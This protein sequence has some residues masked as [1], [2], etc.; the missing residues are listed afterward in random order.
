MKES[1]SIVA[2]VYYVVKRCILGIGAGQAKATAGGHLSV[3]IADAV[4]S[5]LP[6]L[7][8]VSA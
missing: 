8:S 3:G 6:D 4:S 5:T 2:H 7:L 1:G